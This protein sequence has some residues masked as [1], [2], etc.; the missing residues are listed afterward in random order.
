M[1]W[2]L[3]SLS[4]HWLTVPR[5]TPKSCFPSTAC[6]QIRCSK[7]KFKLT[8]CCLALAFLV[9]FGNLSLNPLN[10]FIFSLSIFSFSPN[11][12]SVESALSLLAESSWLF[13]ICDSLTLPR[14]ELM[15]VRKDEKAT[16]NICICIWHIWHRNMRSIIITHF[17]SKWQSDQRWIRFEH[18]GAETHLKLLFETFI[19]I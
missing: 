3:R 13:R 18:F 10:F 4:A 12:P 1:S 5:N 2:Y 17:I 14:E 9:I 6:S 11:L 19:E 8:F 7:K 16:T 15:L